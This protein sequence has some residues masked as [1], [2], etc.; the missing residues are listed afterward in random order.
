MQ[1]EP[2]RKASQ[3]ANPSEHFMLLE[4]ETL[5]A[6]SSGYRYR[7]D[8]SMDIHSRL[9][10]F[11]HSS[12]RATNWRP[13][14]NFVPSTRWQYTTRASDLTPSSGAVTSTCFPG[15]QSNSVWQC[16]FHIGQ[17]VLASSTC[18]L[19]VPYSDAGRVASEY[20]DR[21]SLV[22]QSYFSGKTNNASKQPP[23]VATV[24]QHQES[25]KSKLRSWTNGPAYRRVLGTSEAESAPSHEG[26]LYVRFQERSLRR[27]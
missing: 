22:S 21:G 4:G 12:T 11:P 13:T 23:L 20:K 18:S 7:W 17:W 24:R 8:L 25:R 9:A 10:G 27:W 14:T 5:E 3:S 16:A 26:T 15:A 6:Q 2:M 19:S 1:A